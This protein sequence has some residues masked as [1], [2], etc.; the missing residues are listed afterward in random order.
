[1][2]SFCVI[3]LSELIRLYDVW[4]QLLPEVGPFYAVKVFSDPMVLKVL[5]MLGAGFDC[6][7]LVRKLISSLTVA[8]HNESLSVITYDPFITM[9]WNL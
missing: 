7:S 2:E 4:N 8:T 9:M 5:A 3:D 6:A 1:M